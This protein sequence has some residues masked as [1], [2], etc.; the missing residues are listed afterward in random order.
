MFI[1]SDR[2]NRPNLEDPQR[3]CYAHCPSHTCW[4]DQHNDRREIKLNWS[5][6]RYQIV[7][8]KTEIWGCCI[9]LSW[10]HAEMQKWKNFVYV[11]YFSFILYRRVGTAWECLNCHWNF[12]SRKN[13][14]IFV[15]KYK[16]S[17]FSFLSLILRILM[18]ISE[19]DTN[20]DY[21]IPSYHHHRKNA[22]CFR[23]GYSHALRSY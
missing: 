18:C 16:N 23:I 21:T 11:W 13:E 19:R 8:S 2:E 20:R 12:F 14:L 17:F 6:C 5:C 3:R 4:E 22:K 10:G 15:K 7:T 9:S 1:H